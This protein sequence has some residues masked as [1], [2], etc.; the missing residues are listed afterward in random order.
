MAVRHRDSVRRLAARALDGGGRRVGI[1]TTSWDVAGRCERPVY[2]LHY[3]R[4]AKRVGQ[5]RL[6]AI[7]A[8]GHSSAV[9]LYVPCRRCEPCLRARARLWRDRAASE[10]RL[11]PRTWFVT[12][13]LQPTERLRVISAARKRARDRSEEDFD[14]L[15]EAQRWKR[16]HDQCNPLLTRYLKRLR[17]ATGAPLRY[18]I[19]AEAHKD[20]FPHYHALIHE[21]DPSRPVRKRQIQS[22]WWHGFSTAKVVDDH[23]KAVFYV[24]KYLT[25]AAEARVRA[26]V[27][28]G[29]A[30]S[31]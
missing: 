25:K 29:D 4:P 31:A 23:K 5:P 16:L 24:T 20:G 18:I 28:Y 9:E 2:V 30:L 13:T 15:G 21:V 12:F 27:D 22:Q 8:S 11:W 10:I 14:A 7:Y 6:D 17:K 19:V 3:G 26:S 1:I